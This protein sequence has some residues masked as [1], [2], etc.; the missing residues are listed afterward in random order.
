MD[1][2]KAFTIGT[3]GPVWF[4]HMISLS[5]VDD[6]YYD[7]P[8]KEYS[9][10]LPIYYGIFSI[11]SIIIK[12]EFNL[13]LSMSLFITSIISISY[14]IIQNYYIA[15]KLYKPY[16]NYTPNEWLR[17]FFR[18]GSR[19]LIAFNLVIYYFTKHFSNYYWLRVFIIGSS[20]FSYYLTYLKVIWADNK[21]KLNYKY[22]TFAAGEPLFQGLDLLISLYILQKLLGFSLIPSLILWN[23]VGSLLQV[24]LAY[25][26]KT[27]KYEGKEWLYYFIRAILT[28]FIKII[29]IY[30]LI[31]NLK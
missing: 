4:L 14:F 10:N 27:Y 8:Y 22:Q 7:F 24:F 19:H 1:Y 26:G 15:R 16:K 12:K 17:Y 30:Y 31:T 20:I 25:N 29:P 9:L 3:S 6:K 13:S 18:N 23:I 11:L 5:L 21:N 28:G 2:L